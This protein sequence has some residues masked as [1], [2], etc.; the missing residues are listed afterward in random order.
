M[1]GHVDHRLAGPHVVDGL[2]PNAAV[3]APLIER[4]FG[5]FVTNINFSEPFRSFIVLLK[6]FLRG[7]LQVPCK[8]LEVPVPAQLVA[9]D[10]SF[11]HPVDVHVDSDQNVACLFFVFMIDL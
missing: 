9:D 3:V 6:K 4:F 5:G 1:Q 10:R 8:E 7:V 2:C 11:R